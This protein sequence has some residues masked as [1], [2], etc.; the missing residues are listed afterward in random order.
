MSISSIAGESGLQD[1]R[2]AAASGVQA[3]LRGMDRAARDIAAMNVR[4]EPAAARRPER[5]AAALVDLHSYARQVE[6]SVVA[7]QSADAALG[8]LL[9]IRA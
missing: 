3:G 5:S 6:A 4:D 1:A 9:D 7:L 2:R 8:F